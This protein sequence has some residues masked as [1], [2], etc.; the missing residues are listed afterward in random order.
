MSFWS[1]FKALKT[2]SLIW[3][4]VGVACVLTH[5]A[6][7]KVHRQAHLMGTTFNIIVADEVD[8]ALVLK[9][10]NNAFE[11]IA[12]VESLMSEWQAHSELSRV[13]AA[14]G[15]TAVAVSKDTLTVVETALKIASL[16]GGAFDPSW[17]AL[18]GLWRFDQKKP[19]LPKMT[20]LKA[21]LARVDFNQVEVSKRA[22]TIRLKKPGMVLGLGGVAKGYGIDRA[23]DILLAAGLKNFIVDGGG[24]MY[25]AGQK[26]SGPWKVGIRH[27]R[28]MRLF[29]EIEVSEK[30]VVSS[31]DYERYFM[32]GAKRYHHIID[33]KTGLPAIGAVSVTVLAD[34]TMYADA[35]A[36][37]VFVLGAKT[38][39]KLVESLPGIEAILLAPNGQVFTSS[40][41]T[42]SLPKRWLRASIEV[43]TSK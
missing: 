41:I 29:A 17:A 31:G 9:A 11:E 1:R 35:V 34:K 27:P 22:Q 36:T 26:Q 20:E 30:A 43:P 10:M 42:N 14:A 32:L 2:L 6:T 18:R 19:V 37:A 23:R 33:L 7:A 25:L 28:S 38:G 4:G 40:G 3:L 15:E 5:T 8:E 12:R 16:S 13:N 39:L 24:D 21:A